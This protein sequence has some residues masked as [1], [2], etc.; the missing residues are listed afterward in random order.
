MATDLDTEIA[1]VGAG[2]CGLAAAL[3]A[4]EQGAQ[5]LVLEKEGVAGGNTGISAGLIIAAG[6]HFQRANGEMGTP[7]ELADD[8]F[9]KN[10]HRSDEA[11]TLVLCRASGPLMD[12]L[13][14]HGVE[15]EHLAGYRYPGMSR[16]WLH[17]PPERHGR[18]MIQALLA[19]IQQQ[20]NVDLM[21]NTPVTGLETTDDAVTGVR[22]KIATGEVL[23][24]AARKVIL[25]TDGF[26][27]N[28]EMVSRHIPAMAGALYYGAPGT[29]GET[30]QWGIELGGAADH[31]GSFQPHSSIA[32]PETVFVTSYLIN[33]GAIQVNQAGRRFS[34]ETKGYAGHALAVQAQPG[35]TVYE[36]FDGRIYRMAQANYQRFYECVDAGVIYRADTLAELAAHFE[37]DVGKL[38]ETVAAYTV[39]T[40]RGQDEFGRQDFGEPLQPPYYAIRVTSALVQT[41][42][43]LRI[44]A[45]ARVLRPDGTPVRNLYAGG[46]TAAGFAGDDPEGYLAGVGL[47]AAFGLGRIAGQDAAMAVK[48]FGTEG[49]SGP[50]V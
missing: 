35:R 4:A 39:A 28:R 23:R 2:G 13:A 6:S 41:Q 43:G 1:I 8:I 3:T 24:I 50:K 36:I 44:D 17:A 31:M 26:G 25:A 30:I 10:G 46:G 9:R 14:D 32:Y 5:V 47:L 7:E 45:Q 22:A 15:L 21:L 12:W 29:T 19:A 18:P 16:Y 38:E 27:A 37:L 34:D 42:G 40:A 48:P 33:S 49:P 11:V 20:G